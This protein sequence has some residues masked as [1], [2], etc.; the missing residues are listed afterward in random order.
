MPAP[1]WAQ[2]VEPPA[3]PVTAP[4]TPAAPVT[5]PVWP[6]PSDRALRAET[7][8]RILAAGRVEQAYDAGKDV[9]TGVPLIVYGSLF[10]IVGL[11]V[12]SFSGATV[13]T[14]DEDGEETTE[15]LSSAITLAGMLLTGLG[16]GQLIPGVFLVREG[17]N[18]DARYTAAG[19]T[20]AYE[21]GYDHGVGRTLVIYG[22]VLFLSALA[23]SVSDDRSSGATSNLVLGGAQLLYGGYLWHSGVTDM[24]A[25]RTQA[26]QVNRM[27]RLPPM[28][29]LVRLEF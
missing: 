26:P 3:A 22:S 13:T 25:L 7:A 11:V 18:D 12:L 23:S 15:D 27:P 4:A 16:L 17:R 6:P 29:P 28:L 2:A 8:H 1:L 10:T 5:A 24:N 9:G 20:T 19:G 14:T 21:A